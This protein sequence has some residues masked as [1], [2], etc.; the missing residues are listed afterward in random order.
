MQTITLESFRHGAGAKATALLTASFF[1]F[2]FYLTPANT[3]MAQTQTPQE[4]RKAEL[5]ASKEKTASSKLAHR[6]DKLKHKVTKELPASRAQREA[7]AGF[8]DELFGTAD[9]PITGDEIT[10]LSQLETDIQSAY[11]VAMAEMDAVG[12]S[13]V[14]KNLPQTILDRHDAAKSQIQIK[15]TALMEALNTLNTADS[16][17]DQDIALESLTNELQ[18]Q[19]FKRPNAPFD[20]Q[21]LPFN[22]PS[23]DVRAPATNTAD[24]LTQLKISPFANYTQVA[25]NQM[26]PQLWEDA[27]TQNNGPTQA[28]LDPTLES[29]LTDDIAELVA[30]L[31]H[32]PVDIYTWVHNNIRFIPSYGSIQGAQMTLET[33]RGNAMD[34]ASLLIALLRA[35]GIPARYAYGSIKVPAAELMNWV[36][37][38]QTMQAAGNLM[39]QGGIPRVIMNFDGIDKFMRLEHTWVE[40]YVDFEPSRG[41]KNHYGD[42]WIAMDASYKQYRYTEGYNLQDAV[43]FDAQSLIDD[44]EASATVNEA[45][46]WVQNVPQGSIET[47]LQNYQTQLEDY[48]TNQN[49]DATVGE[50]L[51]L[52]DIEIL[53]SQPLSAGLPYELVSRQQ[54]FSDVPESLRHKFEYTLSTENLGAEGARLITITEPT[55]KL[56]GKGLAMSFKPTSQ[57][58]EDI[59]ASYI[60]EPDS[61]TGEID[62]SQLPN[63]LP[64]YL[65]NLTAE[66]TIDGEVQQT[67]GAGTMGATLYE[68]IGLY[69]PAK[70]WHRSI[71]HPIAG[72]YRAMA[73]DLQGSSPEQAQRLQQQ[74]E[75]TKAILE[76]EDDIQLAT[77]TKHQVVGDLLGSTIFSYFALNNIQDEIAAQSANI[78]TFRAP[79][80]GAF[81]TDI[82][83]SYWFGIPRDV[84]F[85]G[86][87]MDVDLVTSQTVENQNSNDK[88]IQF[89]QAIGSR[90][91]AMEYLVPEQMFSTEENPA[92]GVSAVKALAIASAEGQKIYTIDQNNLSEAM[93]AIQLAEL[94][95][96]EIRNAVLAGNVVTTHQYQ[97]NLNGWIGEG[98]II[99]DLDTGSGSY[100]ISGGANGGSLSISPITRMLGWGQFLED[101]ARAGALSVATGVVVTTLVAYIG[102]TLLLLQGLYECYKEEIKLFSY[103]MLAIIAAIAVGL[104]TQGTGSVPVAIYILA[105]LGVS[106]ASAADFDEEDIENCTNDEFCYLRWEDEDDACFAWSNLGADVVRA[107]KVRAADRRTLCIRNGGIPH[108]DEPPIYTPFRD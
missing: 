70:G 51:G 59:I 31:N 56:A 75:Q 76:S 29:P 22:T 46:G 43:P 49:P 84:S 40:A 37:N 60:P 32:N 9:D 52:K 2:V 30:Q 67:A 97:I 17:E 101:S 54:Y 33:K 100:K 53:P 71:N 7:D 28:D 64:G 80:Y 19:R 61:V 103:V 62:P 104:V 108:P 65:I 48:I 27:F 106:S 20:P 89:N 6:L 66:F 82:T 24:L 42:H 4:I 74:M 105:A 58:D 15:Y 83:T 35:S 39:G 68:T 95:E 44:I 55:V 36:G 21:N 85:S 26:N 96:D 14:A 23:Q 86:L 93:V 11:A 87:V 88:W 5:E 50:V 90:Y 73:L 18:N 34:T 63:S 94:S 3:A 99:L 69:S 1:T 91:S 12:D 13:L 107:C 38:V 25:A 16:E 77:L 41:M 102:G 47:Q 72:E 45:E 79:S 10:Q 98:Y 8:F 78:T 81:R 57:A 92:E